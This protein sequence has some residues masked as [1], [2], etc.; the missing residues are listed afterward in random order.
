M[1]FLCN[2]L[3][4]HIVHY[5]RKVPIYTKDII[6]EK[7]SMSVGLLYFLWREIGQIGVYV[8]RK[9]KG[10]WVIYED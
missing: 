9:I 2:L 6:C 8:E 7:F 4:A 1:R 10:L 3:V 5:C